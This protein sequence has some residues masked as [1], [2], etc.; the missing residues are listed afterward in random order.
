M[1]EKPSEPKLS[2]FVSGILKSTAKGIREKGITDGRLSFE[3]LEFRV[4][5]GMTPIDHQCDAIDEKLLRRWT[6]GEPRKNAYLDSLDEKIALYE[7][8]IDPTPSQTVRLSKI[9]ERRA[10]AIEEW[11]G[12]PRKRP[13]PPS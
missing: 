10:S 3:Q 9:I 4:L 11:G 1:V 13:A 8:L 6:A 7:A 2:K 5:E 12:D